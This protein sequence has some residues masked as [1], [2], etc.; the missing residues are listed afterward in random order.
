M[1][2]RQEYNITHEEAS[3]VVSL[4][5]EYFREGGSNFDNA[6]LEA[7]AQALAWADRINIV[8]EG[9]TGD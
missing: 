2:I 8:P 5:W 6:K 7:A 3:E 1:K 9:E 4:I